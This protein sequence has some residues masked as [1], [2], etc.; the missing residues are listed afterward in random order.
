MI[1]KPFLI[2]RSTSLFDQ[3]HGK[4]AIYQSSVH[5]NHYAIKVLDVEFHNVKALYRRAQEYM[6]RD[7]RLSLGRCRH[8]E[9][10]S[11]IHKI[12]TWHG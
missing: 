1:C 12:G 5:G 11:C 10:S 8:Q 2:K 6:H 9:I 7:R 3:S 4:V